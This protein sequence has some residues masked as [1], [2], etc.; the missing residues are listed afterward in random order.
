MAVPLWG[1]QYRIKST[2]PNDLP[3][4]GKRDTIITNKT[5]DRHT[6]YCAMQCRTIRRLRK[7]EEDT[8]FT[9][10]DGHITQQDVKRS[11]EPNFQHKTVGGSQE[12]T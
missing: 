5:A 2:I 6:A 7:L 11:I 4:M 1:S 10:N 3:D 8:A 12:F 9:D